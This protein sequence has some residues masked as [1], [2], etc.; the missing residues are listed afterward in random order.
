MKRFK[1]DLIG[2][3]FNRWNVIEK[4]KINH[5]IKWKCIC[6][7]G[8]GPKFIRTNLLISGLSKSCGCYRVITCKYAQFISAK[9]RKL[10][11]NE[12][13]KRTLLTY[14]KTNA[15]RRKYDFLLTKEEFLLITQ[16]NCFY[17]NESPNN[18]MKVIVDK[19]N[20]IYEEY[21]YNGLDRIDNDKG[22][23]LENCVSCCAKCNRMKT[24]H[25]LHDFYNHLLKIV[26]FK[27]LLK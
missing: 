16:N 14:Y 22:Y 5:E 18:K 9:K 27:E 1:Y 13:C 26:K 3:K 11:S 8:I 12:K 7:C 20:K 2:K 15:K 17:C 10:P 24:S 21:I 4:V 6:D 19:K 23:T 25:S